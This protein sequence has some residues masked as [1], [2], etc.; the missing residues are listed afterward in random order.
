MIKQFW[1]ILLFCAPIGVRQV[2][3]REVAIPVTHDGLSVLHRHGAAVDEDRHGARRKLQRIAV[4]D[5]E[6]AGLAGFERA[7]A[8]L[9]AEHARRPDRQGVDCG[10]IRQA[11]GDGVAGEL[12]QEPQIVGD[13]ALRIVKADFDARLKTLLQQQLANYEMV[14][15]EEFEIQ[16]RVLAR[17]REKLEALEARLSELERDRG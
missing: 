2:A 7:E 6:I 9:K 1:M 17:T 15:R 16:A 3:A 14:S 4:P 5:D 11:V 12:R 8:R 10:G 13:P